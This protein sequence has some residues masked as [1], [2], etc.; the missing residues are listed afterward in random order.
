MN[1]PL[2]RKSPPCGKTALADELGAGDTGCNIGAT[3]CHVGATG[4]H[5]G[6]L[7]VPVPEGSMGRLPAG[8]VNPPAVAIGRTFVLTAL[9]C[10][11]PAPDAERTP[12][13]LSPLSPPKASEPGTVH[14]LRPV[15]TNPEA[16]MLSRVHQRRAL[17]RCRW[18]SSTGGISGGGPK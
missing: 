11:T 9:D 18:W 10:R 12:P 17:C 3:G 15:T 8:N 7:Y 6:A 16:L 14:P 13:P 2:T 5:V 4:C 1:A